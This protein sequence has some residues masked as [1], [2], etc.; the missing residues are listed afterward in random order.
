MT[1]TQRLAV[2]SIDEQERGASPA[3]TLT[4][5]QRRQIRQASEEAY[6]N[7]RWSVGDHR[8]LMCELQLLARDSFLEGMRQA[9]LKGALAHYKAVLV[10]STAHKES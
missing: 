3:A 8:E 9:R 6:D 1:N 7:L 5:E 2:G 10:E 4:D